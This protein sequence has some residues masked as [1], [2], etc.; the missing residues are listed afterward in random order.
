MSGYLWKV[1]AIRNNGKVTKGMSFELLKTGTS[2]KPGQKEIAD[3]LNNK[4]NS[5]IHDSHCGSGNFE[6]VQ[7]NK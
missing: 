2:A 4:Y 7:L 3:A 1:T 5:N 6:F